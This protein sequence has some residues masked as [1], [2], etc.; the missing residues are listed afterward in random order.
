MRSNQ[1]INDAGTL[2]KV[3]QNVA[4]CQEGAKRS[5]TVKLEA[6]V[7]ILDACGGMYDSVR[8]WECSES[9][10]ILAACNDAAEKDHARE[11]TGELLGC[12]ASQFY[13][14]QPAILDALHRCAESKTPQTYRAVGHKEGKLA[15]TAYDFVYL[16]PNW[17]LQCAQGPAQYCG[18]QEF[19]YKVS[20]AV[21]QT[22]DSVIITDR[23]GVIEY[24]NP[25]FEKATGHSSADVLGK[26]PN[27]LKSGRHD[28]SFYKGLWDTILSGKPSRTVFLNK[29]KNGDLYYEEKTISPLI[30]SKGVVTHFVSTGRDKTEQKKSEEQERA[31]Q[32]ALQNAA[33]EWRT[34]FDAVGSA[35][36]VVD[37]DG[38]IQR[39]NSRARDLMGGNFADLVGRTIRDL[40]EREPWKSTV[41]HLDLMRSSR[42]PISRQFEDPETGKTWN[43]HMARFSYQVLGREMLVVTIRDVTQIEELQGKLRKSESMCAMGSLVAGV[44]HEV[45]N[46]L[47]SISAT[48]DAF[49]LRF[50]ERTECQDYLPV[51]RR[52]LKRLN[53]LMQELLDYGRPVT[54]E[55]SLATLDEVIATAMD[56][57]A[58]LATEKS[59]RILRT[60][61]SG[62][63]KLRMEVPSMVKAFRNLLEN[64]VQ[65][66]PQEGTVRVDAKMA[67]SG[68]SRCVELSVRDD[69]AG[70]AIADLPHVFDPF[71]T[72]RPGGTGLG[73]AIANRIVEEHG[74]K[75]VAQNHA[76]GGA[77]IVV[78]LCADEST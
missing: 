47:F 23:D 64:A 74:G 35:I 72:K 66:A 52:Q 50:G 10:F 4:E 20:T 27:I 26:K 65:H 31:L 29:K 71:F 75:I 17:V 5:E 44:A 73:L 53:D 19:L 32:M 78:S 51:L 39:M 54:L 40:A 25:A 63:P 8:L 41:V 59:V 43:V 22:A 42:H 30:D 6:G 21:D 67:H 57:C 15:V 77:E 68:K 18:I 58:V 34:T 9:G 37:S 24:V 16:A 38:L 7:G 3:L 1:I 55:R 76:G 11:G 36:I 61:P 2:A 69:G 56:S 14:D 48:L 49:E 45:R 70:F 46:P 33:M 13:A 60:I 28:S 12:A 62:L